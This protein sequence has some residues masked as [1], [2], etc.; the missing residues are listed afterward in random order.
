MN[1]ILAVYYH[2]NE[3]MG[4]VHIPHKTKKYY[5]S[6]AIDLNTGEYV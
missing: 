1:D 5:I 4:G 2:W 3:V 6:L